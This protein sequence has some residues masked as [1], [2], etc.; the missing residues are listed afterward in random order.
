MKPKKY[1]IFLSAF[2]FVLSLFLART[3]NAQ[4]NQ[5]AFG[6]AGENGNIGLMYQH[7]QGNDMGN[8]MNKFGQGNEMGNFY[9]YGQAIDNG[10]SMFRYGRENDCDYCGYQFNR[11]A[12]NYSYGG[13]RWIMSPDT[14]NGM[15][16]F[17]YRTD[18]VEGVGPWFWQAYNGFN[19]DDIAPTWYV[20]P[21]NAECFPRWYSDTSLSGPWWWAEWL[22]GN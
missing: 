8:F 12:E 9:K 20:D 18:P 5:N 16:P 17:W 7:G 19:V 13:P 2:I 4:H 21:V 11:G 10:Y 22:S 14:F 6:Q 3:I 15:G 1:F